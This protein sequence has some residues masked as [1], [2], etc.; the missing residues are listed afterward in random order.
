MFQWLEPMADSAPSS[1][2]ASGGYTT[3]H[4]TQNGMRYWAV[5]NLDRGEMDAFAAAFRTAAPLSV[6][7]AR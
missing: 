6:P 2:Q 1:A 4:W 3:A 7:V 5:S